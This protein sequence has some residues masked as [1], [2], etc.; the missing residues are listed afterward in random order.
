MGLP[1][2]MSQTNNKAIQPTAESREIQSLGSGI[3]CIE[4]VGWYSKLSAAADL[5]II[6]EIVLC[7]FPVMEL[8]SNIIREIAYVT[9]AIT[10]M[11]YTPFIT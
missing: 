5:N 4:V 11:A 9:Y 6:Q 3:V 10:L 8:K 7:L 1:R 2:G